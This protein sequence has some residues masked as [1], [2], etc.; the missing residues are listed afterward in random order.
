MV[1][2]E[3]LTLYRVR[4]DDGWVI[5]RHGEQLHHHQDN[6]DPRKASENTTPKTTTARADS[7]LDAAEH[8]DTSPGP[9]APTKTAESE[10]QLESHEEPLNSAGVELQPMESQS[11]ESQTAK[12]QP[13]NLQLNEST[14]SPVISAPSAD[15]TQKLRRSSRVHSQSLRYDG[16]VYNI[17]ILVFVSP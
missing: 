4:L 10:P 6:G 5:R 12:S 1:A 3:G 17:R 11:T 2:R 7:L 15:G 8:S 9:P 14:Q 13:N 16:N